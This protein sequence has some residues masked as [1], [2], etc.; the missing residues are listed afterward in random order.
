[1]PEHSALLAVDMIGSGSSRP[2][3]LSSIPELVGD[4]TQAALRAVGLSSATAQDDQFTGDGFLRAYPSRLLPTL[5]DMVS[6]LDE[7]LA[8][9]NRSAKPEI[10]LRVAVHL[11]PLPADRGFYRPNIDVSRLLGAAAFKQVVHHCRKHITADTFTT[12]LILSDSAYKTVFEG[13]Y[14]RVITRN[15]FAPL[16][17]T[18]NEFNEHS[19]VRVTGVHPTQ[20][21]SIPLKDE[22]APVPPEEST[23]TLGNAPGER[24]ISNGGP[25]R[26]NQVTGDGNTFY[27][28]PNL[29][30]SNYVGG[31]NTGVQ[32]GTFN[33]NLNQGEERR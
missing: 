16:L 31:T 18:N 22:P 15:E 2:E 20:I 33:G 29:N 12:A 32:T 5:V 30:V 21:S 25:V 17:I 26:G 19:W 24:S 14:T 11:G 7:L 13:D 1:M 8:A 10:R 6:V 3:H 23:A 28:T 27:T 4:L 9:H